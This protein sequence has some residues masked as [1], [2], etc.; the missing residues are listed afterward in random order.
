MKAPYK[1]KRRFNNFIRTLMK[2]TA[3]ATGCP[4]PRKKRVPISHKKWVHKRFYVRRKLSKNEQFYI[5]HLMRTAHRRFNPGGFDKCGICLEQFALLKM[6]QGENYTASVDHYLR[7]NH[8][9]SL[10][11]NQIHDT[12]VASC[13]CMMY[14]GNYL[15]GLECPYCHTKIA[16]R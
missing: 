5:T 9:Y 10:I 15:I 6:Q 14:R 12:S 16:S 3:E 2:K 8:F 11:I 1:S 13:D 7:K 4:I